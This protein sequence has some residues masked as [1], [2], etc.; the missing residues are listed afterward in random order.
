MAT[1]WRCAGQ[2]EK[3]SYNPCVRLTLL[4]LEIFVFVLFITERYNE[5]KKRI[6]N[7]LI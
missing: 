7:I 1:L 4:L 2:K 6:E 3:S 5:E